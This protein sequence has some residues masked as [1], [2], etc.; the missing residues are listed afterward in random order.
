M[1][2]WAVGFVMG[3]LTVLAAQRVIDEP[4]RLHCEQVRSEVLLEMY[5]RG[6]QDGCLI[7][8]Y[9]NFNGLGASM[10][11]RLVNKTTSVSC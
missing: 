6:R 3:L 7:N 5:Q 4:E 2:N 8:S 1:A 10:S 9:A 11:N